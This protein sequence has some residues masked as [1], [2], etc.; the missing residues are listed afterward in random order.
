MSAEERA[1]DHWVYR[2]LL[3]MVAELHA[4]GYQRLRVSPGMAPS[5]L[6][7]RC[8]FRAGTDATLRYTSGDGPVCFGWAD[9]AD[10]G[11]AELADKLLARAP[12]LAAAARG[13]D[14][15]YAAWFTAMLVLTAP[16]AL[17]ISY[18][19]YELPT[20]HWPGVGDG[21]EIEIPLPPEP[22]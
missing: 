12:E 9:A 3:H 5:G 8:V 7:W 15:E 19:D 6:Y 20:D 1:H 17:P 11:P 14:P 10:D 13:E 4:R 16:G 2:R 18:A 21:R 22:R